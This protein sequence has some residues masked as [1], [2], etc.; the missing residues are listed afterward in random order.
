MTFNRGDAAALF[1]VFLY[2]LYSTLLRK[3]PA[4]H[5]LSFLV[6]LFAVGAASIAI[7]YLLEIAHGHYMAARVEVPL[8]FLYVG[9]FPSLFAYFFFTRYVVLIGFL[10]DRI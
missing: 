7:P 3:K 8:A 10:R 4:I 6:T 2:S 9:L 1:G 5:Q